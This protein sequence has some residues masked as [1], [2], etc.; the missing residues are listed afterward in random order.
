MATI[1]LVVGNAAAL[2]AGD[3]VLRNR[4][5]ANGHTVVLRSDEEAEY[6]SAYDGVMVSDSCA[7]ATFGA[8][9]D[10]VA[11]PGIALEAPSWRLGT[12]SA[13]T[14]GVTQWSV[15]S[16]AGLNGGLTGTQTVYSTAQ[17]QQGLTVA[18]L[19][20]G[21]QVI[22]TQQGDAT[23]AVYLVYEAGAALAGGAAAPARRAMFR[24][25]DAGA[26]SALNSNGLALLDAV[27]D[28]AYGTGA[29]E[30]TGTAVATFG[31]TATASGT[32]GAPGTTTRHNLCPNPAAANNVSG[33]FA[34]DTS[35]AQVTGQTGLPRT[36]GVT[37]NAGDWT[38]P[39]CDVAVG[40]TYRASGYLKMPG[41][42]GGSG[43]AEIHW[44]SA[45]GWLAASTGAP[46][47]AAAGAVV[48]VDTGADAAPTEAV[49]GILFLS[50]L[51]TGAVLTAVLFEESA[52]LGD[53]FDGE[54]P[55]TWDG[56]AG[57]STSTLVTGGAPE[58]TGTAVASFGGLAAVAS[59]SRETFGSALATLGGLAA[60]TS[61]SRET[62][63]SAV[64]VLG[65]LS[66][67]ASGEVDTAEESG[68]AL[69]SLGGL[70]ATATGVR[71]TAGAATAAFTFA[72]AASGLASGGMQTGSAAAVFGFSAQ[73]GGLV[74]FAPGTE[75]LPDQLGDAARLLVEIAWGADLAA[76]ATGW[77]WTDV[78]R[79]VRADPGISA[80]MG[81]AD[82]AS[83]SQ[84][85]LCGLDLDNT[86]GDY[87]L[88]GW[89]A[90][91]PYVRRNTPVRVRVDPADGSGYR[92]VFYG[93]AD[94]FTPGWDS[95]EGTIP[96]VTLSA[97]GMMRRLGQGSSPVQ[98][99]FRRVMATTS[100]VVA[101]WPFEE[102]EH[103][104]LAK[105]LRG[106]TD[107]S[108]AGE[109][110]WASSTAFIGSGPLPVLKDG[111]FNGSVF[112]YT[113]TGAQ[114][115]RFLILV[116][117]D[118]I[119]DG[120]V[121][122]HIHT[123]GSLSRFDITYEAGSGLLGMYIY[124]RDGSLRA[125]SPAI[126]FAVNGQETRLSIEIRQDGS[127]VDW[128]I[129]AIAP[130]LGV[131]P[132][133]FGQT[134]TGATCG[135]V[136]HIEINPHGN[137]G[138]VVFG[139]LTVENAITDLTEAV[140]P[141]VGYTS[142]YITTSLAGASRLERLVLENDLPLT[143]YTSSFGSL[144]PIT[145]YDRIGPQR[146]A[147]LLDLL[148]D[149]ELADQGQLWDGRD[150]GLSYTTRRYREDGIVALTI[151]AAAGE[152]ATPFAPVD[153]DQRTRNRVEAIRYQGVSA[154][155][156][157]V[158]GPLGTATIGAYETSYTVNL[159]HDVMVVQHAAW[160][161]HQG[162]VEGYR[163]P[164]VTV[165]ARATPHLM[166][167]AVSVVPG[168]RIRVT[169]LRPMLDGFPEDEV[170]LIVE[171]VSHTLSAS[172]GWQVTF[173]CS[174]FS[175]WGIAAA[176]ATTGDTSEF[177]FRL[178]TSDCTVATAATTGQLALTVATPSGPLWTTDDD[179]Y[180][181]T[182][183]VGGIPVVAT[184]C[185]GTTN[186]QVF[187]TESL[188]TNFPVGTPVSLHD[189]RPLGL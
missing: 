4:L 10:T 138:D 126:G 115:V 112:P 114:Q 21:A 189:P 188:P 13:Q 130:V 60:T 90:N 166:P 83:T 16:V 22:A 2:T 72:A 25:L 110:D 175:P 3:T 176:T 64:A 98:S 158:T 63:G 116:P 11:K 124:N 66:A 107:M 100:T 88:G 108:F 93:F 119:A 89:S 174:P 70:T 120:L 173:Q 53:Y 187:V 15:N 48:R 23:K 111:Y 152:L 56:T 52:T 136:S 34:T 12:S 151:D 73:A 163:F 97:S 109:P 61:G 161:V 76:P 101:Y 80:T 185:I 36:T 7:G 41:G 113:N 40:T 157:D 29:A 51:P 24:V 55:G 35:Q 19:G 153:D 54:P 154:T 87:S 155:F 69:A 160:R 65:S 180:P 142:E 38:A 164:S 50:G 127:D 49:E 178:N 31:F 156:E 5:V 171:G 78:T 45:T 159:F 28:W 179:D 27:I 67:T 8:K 26:V 169:G 134:V 139:H 79:D 37:G 148:R 58:V 144:T 145:E 146:I 141:L 46:W 106:G 33:Y 9:Y 150:P 43:A 17:T 92:T 186:T 86:S 121:F 104:T 75:F 91:W 117:D 162:T 39:R 184:D 181:L 20:T 99:A 59:G 135:I 6:T 132:G 94:G 137:L 167:D 147:P 182:L 84:P 14:A 105:N 62:F 82:E 118:G 77:T 96:I 32:G 129:S 30:V 95:M 143:R 74:G 68:S 1:V 128:A 170:S 47:S 18:S 122:A 149:C 123:T 71:S 183:S 131:T 165:D 102:G 81:R 133:G 85:A 177:A 44:Y 125:S 168:D 57:N 140:K 42:V 172:S 103:A